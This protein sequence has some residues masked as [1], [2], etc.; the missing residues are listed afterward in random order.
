MRGVI[1]LCVLLLS[2]CINIYGPEKSEGQENKTSDAG[3]TGMPEKVQTL[4]LSNRSPQELTAAV[5][6]YYRLKGVSLSVQDSGSGLVAGSGNDPQQAAQWLDC[7]SFS[8]PDNLTLDYRLVTQ[9][10]SAGEGS[11]VMIQVTGIAGKVAGDGNDKVKPQE[12][13]STGAFERELAEE[14]RK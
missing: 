11:H 7:G 6:R 8:Q 1:I 4:T 14:L 9:V 12:C 10:W 2:G 3:N 5:V 13:F